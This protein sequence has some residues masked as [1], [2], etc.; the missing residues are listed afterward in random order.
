MT[1]ELK[2]FRLKSAV[3]ANSIA[4]EVVKCLNGGML[5]VP[6]LKVLDWTVRDFF[7]NA[8]SQFWLEE[9]TTDVRN[10]TSIFIHNVPSILS[11]A[12]QKRLAVTMDVDERACG[13]GH[14][15]PRARQLLAAEVVVILTHNGYYCDIDAHK[16]P[17]GQDHATLIKN[18]WKVLPMEQAIFD[19]NSIDE[20]LF[21]ASIGN[22]GFNLDEE[23][24]KMF[25]RREDSMG[26]D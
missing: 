5:C 19:I 17:L 15:C 24:E 26:V 11:K 6:N 20:D 3:Y 13:C 23:L 12:S 1:P 25:E 2:L 9:L 10:G 18:R 4:R 14:C 7:R 8:P 16:K 21:G 22:D